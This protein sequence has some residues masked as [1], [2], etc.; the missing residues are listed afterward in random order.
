MESEGILMNLDSLIGSRDGTVHRNTLVWVSIIK[1][2][3]AKMYGTVLELECKNGNK[4]SSINDD[5][6]W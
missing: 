2:Y 1:P 4:F 6:C 5:G 3:K